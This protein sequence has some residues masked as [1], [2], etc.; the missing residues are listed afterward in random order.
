M[1]VLKHKGTGK[2]AV[3]VSGKNFLDLGVKVTSLEELPDLDYS[4]LNLPPHIIKNGVID[5][6]NLYFYFRSFLEIGEPLWVI[7]F[8]ALDD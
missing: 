3:M 8:K 1:A 6:E 5:K 2:P 7:K 4:N